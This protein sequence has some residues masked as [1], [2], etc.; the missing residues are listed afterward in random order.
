MSELMYVGDGDDKAY[1]TEEDIV[2]IL[3]LLQDNSNG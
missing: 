1:L 3:K 2:R